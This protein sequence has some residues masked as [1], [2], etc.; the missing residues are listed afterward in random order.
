M[1]M[2]PLTRKARMQ[3]EWRPYALEGAESDGAKGT[4]RVMLWDN[5]PHQT[6]QRWYLSFQPRFT[7]GM[8]TLGKFSTMDDAKNHAQAR[9]D[10]APYMHSLP[11]KGLH[12]ERS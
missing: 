2:E 5:L 11:Q 7:R 1:V 3:L 4:W 12:H 9:E 6:G 8:L 10:G